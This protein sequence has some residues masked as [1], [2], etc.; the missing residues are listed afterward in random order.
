MLTKFIFV[1]KCKVFIFM[2]SKKSKIRKAD[3][4]LWQKELLNQYS[5]ADQVGDE[6]ADQRKGG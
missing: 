6:K 1:F 3:F 2:R 4:L 5:R